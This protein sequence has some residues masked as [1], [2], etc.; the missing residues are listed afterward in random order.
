M[1]R[2]TVL[3]LAALTVLGPGCSSPAGNPEATAPNSSQADVSTSSVP[4]FNADSAYGY[5]A[6]QVAFGPRVPGTEAQWNCAAWMEAE[7][8]Q[9]CD[10][11][12]RQETSVTGG[13]QKKLRC[14]NLIGTINPNASRRILLLAHWDSRPWADQETP[15]SSQ[16]IDGADDGA[17]G[18]AVLLELSKIIK[19]HPLPHVGI[20]ILLTDVEDYGKTEWGDDSYAL[21]TQYWAMHPHVP[22]YHANAG[23][24]LDMVGAR[25]ARF[26][27]EGY[28]QQHADGVLKEVWSAARKAGYSSYFV[29]ENGGTITDDHV[30][31]NTILHIP[32]I[33][34]INLPSGSATGF[35]NHWHT[36]K[37]NLDIIDKNTLKA[38]GQT[39]LQYLYTR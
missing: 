21:G 9:S 20:D 12:Y 32:T 16:P 38:V 23:I 10:T 15:P 17:S 30:P 34:I 35:G 4:S 7:L 26:P 19:Q 29:Y 25:N 37:D 14:I 6:S 39:L 11:V 8:K 1:N 22:G 33:D 24:L 31:V 3:L 27:M 13:D 5:I 28:S 2:F 36:R 18:V